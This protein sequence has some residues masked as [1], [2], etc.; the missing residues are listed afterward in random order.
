MSVHVIV[1]CVYRLIIQRKDTPMPPTKHTFNISQEELA[2]R[3]KLLHKDSE[4]QRFMDL[5]TDLGQTRD[6]AFFESKE[7]ERLLSAVSSVN[8]PCFVHDGVP[9]Q[10]LKLALKA[11]TLGCAL[12]AHIAFPDPVSMGYE[13][14]PLTSEQLEQWILVQLGALNAVLQPES[15]RIE[16]IRPH[17]ALYTAMAHREDIAETVANAIRKF[18]TWLPLLGPC[19]PT[20]SN[21]EK[22]HGI[23]TAPEVVLGKRYLANGLEAPQQFSEWLSPSASI[24][25]GRLLIRDSEMLAQNGTR[26]QLEFKSLHISPA[27]PQAEHLAEKLEETL[28]QAIPLNVAAAGISGWLLEY[29]N[30]QDVAEP[31]HMY[32]DY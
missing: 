27:M 4:I 9:D 18:D 6:M 12:G 30:R 15:L 2:K 11:K 10:V 23:I 21:L 29:D 19:S 20:L 7:G 26:L 1:V 32:E 5:N 8:I 28:G 22:S 24:E 3:G 17:G 13:I 31:A 16:H 25:Q 14:L